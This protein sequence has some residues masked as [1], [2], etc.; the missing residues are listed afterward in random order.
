MGRIPSDTH[1]TGPNGV[2]ASESTPRT[3]SMYSSDLFLLGR[4]SDRCGSDPQVVRGAAFSHTN[5]AAV[6]V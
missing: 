1:D 5:H 2:S 4:G 3:C 6:T